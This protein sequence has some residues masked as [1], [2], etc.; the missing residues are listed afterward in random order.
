MPQVAGTLLGYPIVLMGRAGTPAE[1]L[2]WTLPSGLS[3]VTADRSRILDEWSAHW[4]LDSLVHACAQ[5]SAIRLVRWDRFETL[6]RSDGLD[7]LLAFHPWALRYLITR[8]ITKRDLP[9]SQQRTVTGRGLLQIE[10]HVRD[11]AFT[12]GKRQTPD[13]IQRLVLQTLQTQYMDQFEVNSLPL[14]VERVSAIRRSCLVL[15]L[16][17]NE[18]MRATH[19]FT[20]DEAVMISFA[21]V[22]EIASG[23]PGR[24]APQTLNAAG[25]LQNISQEAIDRYL[26]HISISF[27]DFKQAALNPLVRSLDDDYFSLS[28]TIRWPLIVRDGGFLT[29]PIAS[30]LLFRPCRGFRSDAL[31]SLSVSEQKVFHSAV[32]SAHEQSVGEALRAARPDADVR[33]ASEVFRS[34]AKKCD[35]VVVEGNWVTLIETKAHWTPLQVSLGKSREALRADLAS[36]SGLADAVVQLDESAREIREGRTVLP[37]GSTVN[38]LVVL[39]YDQVGLNSPYVTELLEEILRD[40]GQL[41]RRVPIQHCNEDGFLELVHLYAAGKHLGKFLRSKDQNPRHRIEEMPFSVRRVTDQVTHPLVGRWLDDFT[42]LMR[43]FVPNLP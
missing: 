29:P 26:S 7:P 35:W 32:G 39:A 28:P 21:M 16:D 34:K 27:T 17:L 24:F 33:P 23:R 12:G 38:G 8:A 6:V 19:G 4:S 11:A 20:F 18:R 25:T 37:K 5:V 31:S 36:P 22:A 9:D 1:P 13:D 2:R 15:G 10:E 40:R 14:F 42:E 41:Q 3:V 43:H 30:D